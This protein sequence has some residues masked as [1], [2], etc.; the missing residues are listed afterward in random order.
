MNRAPEP[1][2]AGMQ[3]YPH[4]RVPNPPNL[5]GQQDMVSVPTTFPRFATPWG[6]VQLS[7]GLD[8]TDMGRKQTYVAAGYLAAI[9]P[10]YPGSTRQFGRNPADFPIKN[11][12]YQQWDTYVQMTAG[13]EP[14]S[15]PGPGYMMGGTGVLM[16]PGGG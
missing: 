7:N 6:M 16:N 15:G 12:S 11:P 14:V 5:Y 3:A 10:Q 8:R 1:A 2:P 13:Q 4:T 9:S